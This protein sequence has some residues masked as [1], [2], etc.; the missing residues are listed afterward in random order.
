MI[1]VMLSA[2]R[3]SRRSM[4]GRVAALLS[5]AGL[6]TG[7]LAACSGTSSATS[8]AS[9]SSPSAVPTAAR[10]G[11]TTVAPSRSASTASARPTPPGSRSIGLRIGSWMG[12]APS[13]AVYNKELIA[14]Y[15]QLHPGLTITVEYSASSNALDTKMLAETAAG[16]PPDLI[17]IDFYHLQSFA[18]GQVL[19]DLDSF[20]ARSGIDQRNYVSAALAQGRYPQNG[21]KLWAWGTMLSTDVLFYNKA[22]LRRA[23]LLDPGDNLDYQ[24]TALAL[25]QKLTNQSTD[26]SQASWGLDVLLPPHGAFFLTCLDSFGFQEVSAD[27]TKALVDSPASLAEHQYLLDLIQK[28]QVTFPASEWQPLKVK[29]APFETNRVALQIGP[30]SLVSTLQ[31]NP[32]LDWDI[33]W[34]PKGPAG[35][36]SLLIAAPTH[37]LSPLSKHQDEAWGFLSWW[38][39]NQTPAQV[40]FPGNLPSRLVA[41]QQWAKQELQ[42]HPVPA[43]IGKI[44]DIASKLG[45][46]TSVPPH[47]DQVWA[48]YVKQGQQVFAGTVGVT[49]GLRAAA[50]QIN[51]ILAQP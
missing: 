46:P 36:Y 18:R 12:Q 37:G 8:S 27:G 24:T 7:V 3:L 9:A 4:L 38:I 41:L 26:P 15:Q 33:A 2:R 43:S 21:G 42:Q 29:L 48:A 31:T 51:G 50:A 45:V 22:L 5:L 10:T 1:P 30:S 44:V 14:P 40:L 34:P 16:D 49:D 35:Q 20:V 28:Y 23:G 11:A 13:Q 6:G 25:G 19:M 32:S 17:E 39:L 47:A